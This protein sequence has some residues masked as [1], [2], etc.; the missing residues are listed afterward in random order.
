MSENKN[1]LGFLLGAATA[2]S[3]ANDTDRNAA[4]LITQF[5]SN[6]QYDKAGEAFHS[7]AASRSEGLRN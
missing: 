5:S 2:E 7:W 6:G 1:N 4:Q 3:A